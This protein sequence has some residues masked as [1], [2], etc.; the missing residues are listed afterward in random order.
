MRSDAIEVDVVA[1]G[2]F[3]RAAGRH[4]AEVFSVRANDL[5][6]RIADVLVDRIEALLRA[7]AVLVHVVSDGTF[8]P[9][10]Q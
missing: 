7:S 10:S 4:A 9:D 6:F 8:P 2:D 1:G 3:I 5:N